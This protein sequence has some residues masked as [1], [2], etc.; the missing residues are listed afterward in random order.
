VI[1]RRAITVFEAIGSD[2]DLADAWELM[3]LAELW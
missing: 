3:G 1:A 2:G